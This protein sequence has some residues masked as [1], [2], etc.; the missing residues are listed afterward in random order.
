MTR[1]PYLEKRI[2]QGELFLSANPR[3]K[4]AISLYWQYM[5]EYVTLKEQE[6]READIAAIWLQL[7]PGV[8]WQRRGAAVACDEVRVVYA[9]DATADRE[10]TRDELRELVETVKMTKEASC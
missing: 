1:I 2:A 6:E 3:D 5:R 10:I 8:K 7:P 4:E 9:G